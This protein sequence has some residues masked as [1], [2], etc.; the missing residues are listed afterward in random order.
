MPPPPN[1][2]RKGD[3]LEK[4]IFD[5]FQMEID[6]D[7]FWARK[8]DCKVFWK[9][10]YYSKDRERDIIFDVAIELYMPGAKEYSCVVLIECKNY[11]HPVP[12]D[13]VEEF[14]TKVQQVGAANSKA[15]V[16]ST[17]S[18]QSGAC[19][20]A[21]SKGI[22]LMRYFSA[23]NFKWELM[24]SPSATAR[25]TSA[26]NIPLIQ[27]GLR[28]QDFRSSAFDL[29]MQSP[30][31]ETNSLWDF[32]EDLMLDV[33][34][35]RKIANS[36]A[37][38][39]NLVPFYEK[40]ELESKSIEML[41]TLAYAGGEVDLHELCACEEKRTGL[42]VETGIMPPKS[43]A[44]SDVLGRITFDPLVIQIYAQDVPH[45]GRDRFTLAHEIAHH[46][47]G[48]GNYMVQE[49]CDNTDFVLQRGVAV[50]GSDV[51]RMEYQANF[52]A[53]SLLMPRTHIINDFHRLARSLDI[54]DKGF[55]A[56][57]VDDQPCNVR[58]LDVISRQ[59]MQIYGV[60]RAAATIRLESI[61]LL[62]DERK[63]TGLRP[64]QDI[65]AP[66]NN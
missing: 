33:A 1:S 54:A 7:R 26:A 57:Y 23:E 51:A 41:T 58:N 47:L 12:V 45:R 6:A 11:S 59:L 37:K 16:V 34:E 2:T 22:G 5:L 61:G 53:A 10:G 13:D 25:S 48:H 3:A 44:L 27:T 17:A 32:F 66:L 21:K 19:I 38:S 28:Q 18:F 50:S 55:G 40:D 36:R 49:Y 35:V 46:F 63:Q 52:L 64:F 39:A 24:R 31:C 4:Q 30:V 14:F 15:I 56:L 20:F 8:A 9:K 60:S 65:Y 62:H 43:H 29:F 42:V